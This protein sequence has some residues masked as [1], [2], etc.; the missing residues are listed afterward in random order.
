MQRVKQ[1]LR[2]RCSHRNY[3]AKKCKNKSK[4][5]QRHWSLFGRIARIWSSRSRP[6][7]F[8]HRLSKMSASCPTRNPLR[9]EFLRAGYD[10]W[11]YRLGTNLAL[12]NASVR[13]YRRSFAFRSPGS[14]NSWRRMKFYGR[15]NQS[16]K[17]REANVSELHRALPRP[18][19]SAPPPNEP[20]LTGCKKSRNTTPSGGVPRTR[21]F[22]WGS[23]RDGASH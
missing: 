9:S 7:A 21:R 22:Q 13:F 8:V 3:V 15:W 11:V 10:R 5:V 2:M 18:W 1:P 23:D 17:N 14:T 6:F 20:A 16:A 19:T 4:T 12:R